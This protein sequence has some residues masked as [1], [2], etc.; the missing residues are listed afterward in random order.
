LAYLHIIE[1]RIKGIELIRPGQ[2]PLAAQHLRAQFTGT[3]VAA[4]GFTRHSAKAI[5]EAGYADLVAF[6]LESR[7]P[8]PFQNRGA[9]EQLRAQHVLWWRRTR[10][11]GLRLTWRKRGPGIGVRLNRARMV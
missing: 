10:I 5:L 9:I 3:I 11:H 7:S 6:D 8:A 2:E 1:P 4:G